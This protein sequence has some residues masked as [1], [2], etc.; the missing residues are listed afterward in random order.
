MVRSLE[1][2][3]DVFAANHRDGKESMKQKTKVISGNLVELLNGGH[4]TGTLE[5]R[6]EEWAGQ[7]QEK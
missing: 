5:W 2:R 3:A 1:T 6:R 4:A 7:L